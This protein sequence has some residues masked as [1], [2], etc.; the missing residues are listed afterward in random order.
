MNLFFHVPV[1]V[2]VLKKTQH[3]RASPY[4]TGLDWKN[5]AHTDVHE[6]KNGF[7]KHSDRVALL[8][9]ADTQ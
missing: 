7:D 6:R 8:G 1:S 9:D 3:G 4:W 2:S 5:I